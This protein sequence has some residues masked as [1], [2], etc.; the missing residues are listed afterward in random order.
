MKKLIAVL[1]AG[2]SGGVLAAGSVD[3]RYASGS[4]EL[5]DDRAQLKLES[6]DLQGVYVR[7]YVDATPHVFV[8]AE[9]LGSKADE[10]EINGADIDADF[11]FDSARGGVGL[12]GGTTFLYFGAVEYEQTEIE[13]DGDKGKDDGVILSVGLKDAHA[14][15]L[16]WNAELGF[17]KLGGEGDSD[18]IGVAYLDL[19]LGYRFTPGIALVSGLHG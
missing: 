8:R 14:G 5:D 11:K 9:Y 10:L 4:F 2:A 6:E 17:A 12:Q 16:L 15:K 13:I 7:G 1:A 3:A 19:G 18:G